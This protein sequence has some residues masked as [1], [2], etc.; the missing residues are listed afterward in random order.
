MFL[1]VRTLRRLNDL[2]SPQDLKALWRRY[3]IA[4]ALIFGLLMTSHI[5][6]REALHQGAQD[7]STINMSGRQRMLLQRIAHIADDYSETYDLEDRNELQTNARLFEESHAKLISRSQSAKLAH[8]LY[9]GGSE[10]L[11]QQIQAML[12]HVDRLLDEPENGAGHAKAVQQMADGVLARRLNDAVSTWETV[13]DRRRATLTQIQDLSL[14]AGVLMLFAEILLIFWPSHQTISR[15][16]ERLQAESDTSE[17]T[18]DRL[19]NFAS[20]AA[21][22]FWETDA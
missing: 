6:S 9:T 22:L 18:L 19:S 14:M 4:L 1:G 17:Q 15:A 2:S 20:V 13:S 16:F 8:D 11:N 5:V 21:D 3:I 10:P 12:L 7:A